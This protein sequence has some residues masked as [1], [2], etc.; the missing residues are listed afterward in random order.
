MT[1]DAPAYGL[2][3]L[4][5]ASSVLFLMF[6]FSFGKPQSP[7]DWRSFGMFSAFVVALFVEMYGFPLS[8]YMIP[9][10]LQT[11]YPGLDLMFPALVVMYVRLAHAEEAEARLRFGDGYVQYAARVP[12][13]LPRPRNR[14]SQGGP[15]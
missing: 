14:S 2:W 8:I 12:G 5:A 1:D 10:W 13:W 7:R 9:G 11:R 6:A 4:A 3:L 15:A